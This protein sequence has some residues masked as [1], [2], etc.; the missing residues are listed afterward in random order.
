M[1]TVQHGKKKMRIVNGVLVEEGATPQQGFREPPQN[2]PFNLFGSNSSNTQ[3]STQSQQ[4][5]HQQRQRQT[6]EEMVIPYGL[7]IVVLLM[8]E[9]LFFDWIIVA[10]TALCSILLLSYIIATTQ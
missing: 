6:N 1:A 7:P 10:I 3:Q 5:S 4:Q 9:A 2:Q 8:A